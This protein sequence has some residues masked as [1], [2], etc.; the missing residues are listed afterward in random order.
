MTVPRLG[1]VLLLATV[2]CAPVPE[3]QWLLG[4]PELL[5][6]RLEVVAEGE[7]S[8]PVASPPA[9]R[10]RSEMLPGD[11][12]LL[13]PWVTGATQVFAEETLDLAYFACYATYCPSAVRSASA[14]EP[15]GDTVDLRSPVCFIGRGSGVEFTLPTEG[16]QALFAGLTEIMAVGG[17]PG[18]GDTDACI[19]AVRAQ[20]FG[21]LGDCMLLT[22]YVAVGP[23]WVV[24]LLQAADD[25]EEL[26]GV[27]TDDDADSGTDTDD[28]RFVPPPEVYFEWPNFSPEAERFVMVV[29]RRG[30]SRA[31][32]LRAGDRIAV[33]ARDR[34]AL[35]MHP[36]PRDSQRYA[37]SIDDD[38]QVVRFE[39][40]VTQLWFANH[41]AVGLEEEAAVAPVIDFEVPGD[42]PELRLDVRL[43]D[44]RGGVGWASLHFEVDATR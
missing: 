26:G 40:L 17:L 32:D 35:Q 9:D 30:S 4:E 22:R 43:D 23:R 37:T 44:G 1:P 5:A 8:A 27:D 33:R 39:E 18:V 14:M 7:A 16:L 11:T 13:R 19:A 6:L 36:D 41:P 38:G 42:V 34:V 25:G 24:T 2:A 20:P 31:W 15:C 10:R 3:P 12:A 21:E 29:T 28:D